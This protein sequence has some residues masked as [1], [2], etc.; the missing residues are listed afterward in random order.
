MVHIQP[1]ATEGSIET[2]STEQ[3]WELVDAATVGRLGFV[4]DETVQI[5]P[6]NY[7]V[8]ENNII[9][10]TRSTGIL[11]QLAG[12]PPVAF[13]VD[14]HGAAGIGWSVLMNGPLVALNEE[15]IKELQ[16]TNRVMPWAGGD[17]DL[18]VRF[19]PERIS[20]RRVR[21]TRNRQRH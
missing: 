21:R 10:R 5:I 11:A 1:A 20:G 6:V 16:I 9:I 3:C 7:T 4:T 19:T 8:A 18:F 13:Q 14:Y 17:R 2:L 15:Q 12:G